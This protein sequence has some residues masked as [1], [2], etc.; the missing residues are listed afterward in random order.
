MS[1]S[2]IKLGGHILNLIIVCTLTFVL[3]L[4]ILFFVKKKLL[5][6][7]AYFLMLSLFLTFS[8][9]KII[10]IRD[11]IPGNFKENVI[12]YDLKKVNGKFY[13][14]ND[15]IVTIN[16]ASNKE[17]KDKLTVPFEYCHIHELDNT[18]EKANLLI[19]S[20]VLKNNLFKL[21]YGT[22]CP[23]IYEVKIE[24]IKLK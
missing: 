22:I 18:G 19:H 4:V 20:Y 3:Y 15:G 21:L 7:I 1:L 14:I 13:D 24:K 8:V 10:S 16:L 2:K 11:D 9:K 17:N 12:S 6:T 5:L 23:D